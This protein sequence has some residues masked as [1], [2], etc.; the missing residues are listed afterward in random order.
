[1]RCLAF[2]S[3]VLFATAA[4]P[5]SGRLAGSDAAVATQGGQSCNALKTCISFTDS[6]RP[7]RLNGRGGQPPDYDFNY[8]ADANQ[9]STGNTFKYIYEHQIQNKSARNVL[10]A[11][12]HDG[13]IPFQLIP[14]CDCAPGYRESTIEPKEKDDSEI[15]YGQAKQFP[16]VPQPLSAYVA[17]NHVRNSTALPPSLMTR[18]FARVSDYVLDLLFTTEA[19]SENRFRYTILNKSSGNGTLLFSIPAVTTRW[20]QFQPL[21][22]ALEGST[23]QTAGQPIAA[24]SFFVAPTSSLAV[25]T[26]VAPPGT[27]LREEAAEVSVAL[28]SRDRLLASGAVSVY[29]PV[30]R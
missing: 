2:A 23:W 1:M 30:R 6:S 10:W 18:L 5:V 20:A 21:G 25:W 15:R 17:L 7:P 3:L 4:W 24:D 16:Q 26:V 8:T 22:S 19:L 28:N 29:L 12:W 13:T 27:N 14:P 11:E 9:S